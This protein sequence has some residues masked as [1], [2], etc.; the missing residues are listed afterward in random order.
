MSIIAEER[1]HFNGGVGGVECD[2][3]LCW[4]AP[5]RVSVEEAPQPKLEFD[6]NILQQH[7]TLLI[8]S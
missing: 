2:A 6:S 5:R 1:E 7:S 8:K 3:V 4:F